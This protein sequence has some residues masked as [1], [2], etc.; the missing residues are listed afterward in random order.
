MLKKLRR[1]LAL[2]AP[3]IFYHLARTWRIRVSGELP[4][5]VAVIAF[6]HGDM[7]P[8]WKH[9]ADTQSMALISLSRDGSLLANLVERWG[10][11]T[12]RGSSSKGGSEALTNMVSALH[13]GK[14]V[15][16]T[17]DGPRGPR[18]HM[19]PGAVIAAHRAG[20]SLVL[21]RVSVSSSVHGSNWDRF[22]IP[23]PFA[24]IELE[25]ITLAIPDNADRKKLD[26][27]NI[28]AECLLKK[29]TPLL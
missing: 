20:V 24:S 7:L 3:A 21:C 11:E 22:L 13:M 2:L 17:P 23:L 28:Y 16:I 29:L 25:F 1:R 14:R 27:L 18:H 8:V 12:V 10:F 6:W 5:G 15:L 19:K 4:E 26:R 9:F